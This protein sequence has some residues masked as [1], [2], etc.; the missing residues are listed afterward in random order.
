MFSPINRRPP[1]SMNPDEAAVDPREI[2]RVLSELA[3]MIG[4]WSLFRKFLA[5][6]LSVYIFLQL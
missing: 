4:R 1:A 3:G 6:A 5:E 2:D